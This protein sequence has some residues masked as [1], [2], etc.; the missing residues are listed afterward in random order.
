MRPIGGTSHP[1]AVRQFHDQ[2]MRFLLDTGE[3]DDG[4]AK[5]CWRMG[6]W[7]KYLLAPLLAL[8]QVRFSSA[9]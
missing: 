6:Q 9:R 2:D 1:F 7:H 8:A 4:I 3:D 5:I